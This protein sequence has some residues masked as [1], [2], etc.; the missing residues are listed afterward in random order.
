MAAASRM[1]DKGSAG[2]PSSTRGK[3]PLPGGLWPWVL[4]GRRT[5][6]ALQIAMAAFDAGVPVM[7]VSG[8][9]KGKTATIQS[10]MQTLGWRYHYMSMASLSF[11]DVSGNPRAV[12]Y[13]GPAALDGGSEANKQTVYAMPG[14]QWSLLEQD[15]EEGTRTALIVDELNTASRATLKTFLPIF[16]SKALP[17]GYRFRADTPIIGAMNPTDQ[18]DGYELSM[19]MQNRLLWLTWEPDPEEMGDG[20]EARWVS[21]EKMTLPVTLDPETDAAEILERERAYA[22]TARQYRDDVMGGD[23]SRPPER[24]ETAD[25]GLTADESFVASQ[26]WSSDRSWDNLVRILARV[27][28]EA[29]TRSLLDSLVYGTVGRRWG[30]AYSTIM[31]GEIAGESSSML[32]YATALDDFDSIDWGRL[33]PIDLGLVKAGV[34]ADIASGDA[35][36]AE[37]AISLL[38]SIHDANAALDDPTVIRAVN[39]DIGLWTRTLGKKAKP[40]RP[41]FTARFDEILRLGD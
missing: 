22:K 34:A 5:T 28:V 29:I 6:E 25:D 11:D 13:N 38:T 18:S 8:P 15:C 36:R 10:L 16:Q 37:R 2:D 12:D 30:A 14:W 31:F 3:G 19:A 7:L 35:D 32:K 4:Q 21:E 40:L 20:F 33:S 41:A 1:E 27:P 26:A 9:G 39:D 23:F 24:G 17:S